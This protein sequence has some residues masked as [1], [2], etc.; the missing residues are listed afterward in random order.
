MRYG[1]ML[2]S[3][4]DVVQQALKEGKTLDQKEA[5]EAT[6]PVEKIFWTLHTEDI[7]L[8]TLY[9]SLTGQKTGK[10]IMHN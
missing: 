4:R 6:R 5:G 1:I 7:F 10:L 3:T 2:K 9:K 8:E